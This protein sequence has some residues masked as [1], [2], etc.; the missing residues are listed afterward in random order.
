LNYRARFCRIGSQAATLACLALER[1]SMRHFLFDFVDFIEACFWLAVLAFVGAVFAGARLRSIFSAFAEFKAPLIVIVMAFL[2]YQTPQMREV[3][4]IEYSGG[5]PSGQ[6][7]LLATAR[8]IFDLVQTMVSRDPSSL[9]SILILTVALGIWP[10]THY[11][12]ENLL[13][14]IW[15]AVTKRES[16]H[17]TLFGANRSLLAWPIAWLFPT[18]IFANALAAS[19]PKLSYSLYILT[20]A[21]F[22]A[23]PV[24]ALL[25]IR[26]RK[27]TISLLDSNSS[28]TNIIALLIFAAISICGVFV[29][30]PVIF[31][32][33]DFSVLSPFQNEIIL[34][35]AFLAG[36][37]SLFSFLLFCSRFHRAI[38]ERL[39][40]Q[41][42]VASTAPLPAASTNGATP[43]ER[44]RPIIAIMILIPFAL[45]TFD[46]N[47]NY[48][49]DG[50]PSSGSNTGLP[51][52]EDAFT[53]WLDSRPERKPGDADY[54]VYVIAAQGGG[55]YAAYH[56]GM[57]LA[58]V[59]D[60]YP[61][62]AE[63]I[64]AISA[65]SGGSLGAATFASLVKHVEIEKKAPWYSNEARAF[66]SQDF[67]S[68]LLSAG[69]FLDL[70]AHLLL[71]RNAFC[72]GSRLS[73]AR[74]LE[75]SIESAWPLLFP[76]DADE[77]KNPFKRGVRDLWDPK[78]KTPA[79]LLNSTEVE[80]GDRIVIAPWQL[81]DASTPGLFGFSDR[82]DMQIPLSTAISL[83]ARFPWITPAG[84]LFEKVGAK[85]RLVDGGYADNSGLATALDVIT[86]L[87]NRS[88]VRFI[89][90]ALVSEPDNA[91][92]PPSHFFGEILSPLRALDGTRS[93]RGRLGVE[94]AELYLN[95]SQCPKAEPAD[96]CTFRGAMREAVLATGE[97]RVPL[98]WV[99]SSYSRQAIECSFQLTEN[100][101]KQDIFWRSQNTQ[102]I[103]Q[104]GRDLEEPRKKPSK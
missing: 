52:L 9:I 46:L 7:T 69:L 94:Q 34:V 61:A 102:L 88:G 57:F 104:I 90:I 51:T 5:R 96:G 77:A 13:P 53:Q 15:Q 76:S 62:F 11:D 80:T 1:Y 97:V 91:A 18:I 48:K 89:V 100:C 93:A 33:F 58:A 39:A 71:C 8:E 87:K 14:R 59:Q 45:A 22:Y 78:G 25:L 24:G 95:R 66:L 38:P 83:S 44:R 31:L 6:Q 50:L 55:I 32:I 99:L 85:R 37:L 60:K 4:W 82:T 26:S 20:L 2:I 21:V 92:E 35:N 42:P 54:P 49:I 86:R 23:I 81:E 43:G 63:H 27:L 41:S 70:P 47:D 10:G 19:F 68:E 12:Y 72:P 64:F 65:V 28:I 73:R 79:L 40:P 74:G 29:L 98:G 67:L 75:R 30:A 56:A 84:W 36:S 16:L 3:L 103:E 17:G 101:G